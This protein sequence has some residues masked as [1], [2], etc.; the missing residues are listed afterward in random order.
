MSQGYLCTLHNLTF[1]TNDESDFHQLNSKCYGP[2]F[3]RR[4]RIK[5]QIQKLLGRKENPDG[6]RIGKTIYEGRKPE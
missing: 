4:N 3:F 6:Y 5:L 1:E 2:F